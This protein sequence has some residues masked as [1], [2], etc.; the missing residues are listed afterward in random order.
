MS[1]TWVH[2]GISLLDAAKPLARRL[3]WVLPLS[4]L[5][6]LY[7]HL[8][9]CRIRAL[10]DRVFMEQVLI[11]H[12]RARGVRQAL[13]IGCRPYTSHY[14][15]LFS[16]AGI[17]LWTV[18]IDA[19]A[20]AFGHAGHH[21]TAS[22]LALRPA[23]FPVRLDAAVV[24]GVFGYGVNQAADIDRALRV[25]AQLLP[26]GASLLLGWNRDRSVDPLTLPSAAAFAPL[27]L[28]D[29]RTRVDFTQ[30]THVY[31]S[32]VRAAH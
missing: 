32:M 24:N 11:E 27:P 19:Q 18:D 20:A 26:T 7:W 1:R 28:A 15:R 12:L 4:T 25:L 17:T 13:F 22:L 3:H 2:M 16:A 23:D 21:L 6:R 10:E 29:G 9:T 8:Q 14:P 5:R 31:D 30:V